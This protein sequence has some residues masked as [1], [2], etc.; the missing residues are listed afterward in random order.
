MGS[1]EMLI[2]ISAGILTCLR[3]ALI[4]ADWLMPVIKR[5]LH[6]LRVQKCILLHGKYRSLSGHH[7]SS[8]TDLD[9]SLCIW[10]FVHVTSCSFEFMKV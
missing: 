7:L 8:N 3:I 5:V 2:R 9:S 6:R 10:I 4:L 1:S